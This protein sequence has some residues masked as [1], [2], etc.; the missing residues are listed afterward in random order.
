MFQFHK[1]MSVISI[2][3]GVINLINYLTANNNYIFLS[4][5]LSSL[6]KEL[7]EF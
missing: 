2:T 7:N 6:K 4:K 1:N 5:K 3:I